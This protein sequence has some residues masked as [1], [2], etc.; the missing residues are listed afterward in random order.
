MAHVLYTPEQAARATLASLR[1]LTNLPRTVRQDFSA[2]FVAGRGPVSYTH[3]TLPTN[4][5]V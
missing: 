4:R 3:L 5:E 1:W 2:E